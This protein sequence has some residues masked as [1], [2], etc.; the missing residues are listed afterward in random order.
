MEPAQLPALAK[1]GAQA[2]LLGLWAT[3]PR[4]HL[5]DPYGLCAA[6]FDTCFEVIDSAVERIVRIAPRAAIA[7]SRLNSRRESSAR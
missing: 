2:T 4:P 6:Y 7:D 1:L 3:P 5:E